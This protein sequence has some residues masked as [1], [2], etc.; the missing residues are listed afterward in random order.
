[1]IVLKDGQTNNVWGEGATQEQAWA[2][3]IE[4]GM[5][6]DGE[7]VGEAVLSEWLAKGRLEWSEE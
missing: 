4:N 1:M 5:T 3:A 7:Y 2:D 6:S